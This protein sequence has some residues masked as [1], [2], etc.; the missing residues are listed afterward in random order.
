MI[1]LNVEMQGEAIT[2]VDADGGGEAGNSR[3]PGI[4]PPTGRQ[5]N[6]E[7]IY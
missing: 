2:P 5:L 7:Y 6:P 1:T 3:R 4:N